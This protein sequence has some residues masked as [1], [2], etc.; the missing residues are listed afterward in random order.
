M[1]SQHL[2]PHLQYQALLLLPG[3]SAP[4]PA[5]ARIPRMETETKHQMWGAFGTCSPQRSQERETYQIRHPSFQPKK[6][7]KKIK[8]SPEQAGRGENKQQ[9]SVTLRKGKQYRPSE[10]WFREETSKAD[11][12]LVRMTER[13]GGRQITRIRNATKTP[14]PTLQTLKESGRQGTACT[15]AGS[16]WHLA[17]WC[18]ALPSD[19]FLLARLLV[20]VVEGTV[21]PGGA[22]D[23]ICHLEF[24]SP[25]TRS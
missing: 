1:G 15:D 3:P 6:L 18:P 24:S 12:S 20:S 7:R 17:P 25:D 11:K 9:K 5:E 23:V 8:M 13:K 10:C 21:F 4:R 2:C 14:L 19:H 22:S 16:P